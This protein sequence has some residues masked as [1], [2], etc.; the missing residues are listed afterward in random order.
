M[1]DAIALDVQLVERSRIR[2]TLAYGG[3][4]PIEIYES[5]L[6]WRNRY[7]LILAAAK[8]DAVGT[9]LPQDYV[10]DDPGPSSMVVQP[11]DR[12]TGEIDLDARFAGLREALKT[13]DVN[14]FWSYEMR[15]VENNAMPRVGGWL[16]IPKAND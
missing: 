14:L 4:R 5:A 3:D 11:G 12:L 2:L 7:S 10:I 1:P 6:P 9:L 8:A 13:Y 16:L 15:T